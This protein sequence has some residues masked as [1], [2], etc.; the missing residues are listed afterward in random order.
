MRSTVG[1]S[2]DPAEIGQMLGR[3]KRGEFVELHA[4]VAELTTKRAPLFR[5]GPPPR[6]EMRSCWHGG[7]QAAILRSP[8]QSVRNPTTWFQ[9]GIIGDARDAFFPETQT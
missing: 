9:L 5:H 3:Q 2:L 1:Q 7:R 6:L 8:S 4:E